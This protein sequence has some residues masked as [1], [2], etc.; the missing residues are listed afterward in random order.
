MK[1]IKT[2]RESQM[3]FPILDNFRVMKMTVSSKSILSLSGSLASYTYLILLRSFCVWRKH[4]GIKKTSLL[5][6]LDHEHI[7][8][9]CFLFNNNNAR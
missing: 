3:G 4:S 6:S 7:V 1:T 8:H 9:R 5:R 2:A